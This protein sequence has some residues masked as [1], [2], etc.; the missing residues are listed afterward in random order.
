[1]INENCRIG[2]PGIILSH[3]RSPRAHER[4]CMS[5][6][7][8]IISIR[9]QQEHT[10][11]FKRCYY[12]T[13]LQECFLPHYPNPSTYY[14][15]AVRNKRPKLFALIKPLLLMLRR[16]PSTPHLIK[17]HVLNNMVLLN[18]WKVGPPRSI[19]INFTVHPKLILIYIHS[20]IATVKNCF[21][22]LQVA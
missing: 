22:L 19:W 17:H 18:P 15:C 9:S 8:S 6:V 11:F 20:L 12:C 2:I 5:S 10:I 13:I 16:K 14:S 7:L 1:M 4:P 3:V 21:I